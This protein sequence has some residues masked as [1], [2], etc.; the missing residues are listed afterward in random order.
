[1]IRLW[2]RREGFFPSYG[3]SDIISSDGTVNLPNL[4]WHYRQHVEP[5]DV[6]IGLDILTK[7]YRI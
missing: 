7:G 3:P 6:K 5:T 2:I 1:M 4:A